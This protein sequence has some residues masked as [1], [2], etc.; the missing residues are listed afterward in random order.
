MHIR[1]VVILLSFALAASPAA[2]NLEIGGAGGFGVTRGLTITNAG[3]SADAGLKNGP[4]FSAVVTHHMYRLLSGELRY[5]F[6]QG[7][8]QLKSGGTEATF[9]AQTHSVHYDFLFFTQDRGAKIRPFVAA[10]AGIRYFRGTGTE[11]AVQPLSTFA[12]LTKTNDYRPLV[13]LG[14]GVEVKAAQRVF[15]RLEF[16]DFLTP[17]PDKV[18]VT[19]PGASAK[20]WIHDLTPMIGLSFAL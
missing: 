10:G 13:S 9:G 12:L 6:R 8:L 18:I 17:R 11:V 3:G 7:A 5:G 15:L 1:N 2:E 4:L 19:A 20:G 14:G 16:R